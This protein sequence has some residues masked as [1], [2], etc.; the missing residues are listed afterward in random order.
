VFGQLDEL[1][2]HRAGLRY[3]RQDGYGS[4]NGSQWRNGQGGA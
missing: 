3:G 4:R 1:V 2:D